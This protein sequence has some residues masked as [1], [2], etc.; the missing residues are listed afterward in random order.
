MNRCTCCICHTNFTR[1][2]R[3]ISRPFSNLCLFNGFGAICTLHYMDHVQ[4]QSLSWWLVPSWPLR[5]CDRWDNRNF[6]DKNIGTIMMMSSNGNIFCVTGLCGGIHRSP[7]NSPHKGQWRRA[8]IFSLVCAW[9][10]GWANSLEADDLRRH[11][12]HCDVIVMI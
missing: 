3:P 10:N 7:V 8:L 2:E 11:R 12:P 4:L 9:I 6:Q 1:M 5:A